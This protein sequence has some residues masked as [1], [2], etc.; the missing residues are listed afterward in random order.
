MGNMVFHEDNPFNPF[1]ITIGPDEI[2]DG[3]ITRRPIEAGPRF[4]SQN[5]DTWHVGAGLDGELDFGDSSWYWDVQSS[6]AQNTANQSKTGAFNARNIATA[7]GDPDICDATPGC[8]PF[9]WFGGQG[10]NGEGS[11][12]QEML[13]YVTFTQKDES[14]QKMFNVSANISGDIVDLPAGPLSAAFGF[15][16]RERYCVD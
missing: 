15:E 6:W 9:N 5:V 11:I 16:Y 4:F 13:D 14:E 8:V 12:T 2:Q 10:P 1:G 3:F 7:V